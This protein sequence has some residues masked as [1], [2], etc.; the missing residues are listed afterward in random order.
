MRATRFQTGRKGNR[1]SGRDGAA[2]VTIL[3]VSLIL[4]IAGAA[5]LVLSGQSAHRIRR[6]VFGAQAQAV[7]EAGIADMVAKLGTNY[8]AWE[9]A[10]YTATFLSGGVYRVTTQLQSNGN[11]LI[12]SDGLYQGASNRTIMELLGTLTTRYNELYNL[13]SA[14]LSGGNVS[15]ATAAFNMDGDIHGNADVTGS[16]GA[17]NGTIDGVISAGGTV[18]SNLGGS[19]HTSGVP[20]IVLPP[21]GP[22]NFD[23]YRTLAISNGVYL[24]GN[25]ALSGTPIATAPNYILYVN[26]NLTINGNSTYTGTIVA[27]GNITVNNQ[28]TQTQPAGVSNMPSLLATGSISLYNHEEFNGVMF[29][30]VNIDIENHITINGGVIAG[31]ATSLRNNVTIHHGTAYPAWDPLNPEVPPEVIVGGWLK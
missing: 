20:P 28:F 29:A 19:S 25:Q 6:T 11:V 26:G 16:S 5:L 27:N 14:I 17:Q 22:F 2:L 8:T 12:I 15:F 21:E 1:A 30:R 23:S 7:A 24:E 3:I 18:D 9:N 13:G 4:M 31:G 10:T